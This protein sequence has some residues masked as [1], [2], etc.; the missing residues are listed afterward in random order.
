MLFRMLRRHIPA[1]RTVCSLRFVGNRVKI[2]SHG[3]SHVHWLDAV[4]L[5]HAVF[6]RMI[7]LGWK[8]PQAEFIFERETFK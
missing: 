8:P 6:E 2:D 5:A 4:T 7:I 3:K 1:E